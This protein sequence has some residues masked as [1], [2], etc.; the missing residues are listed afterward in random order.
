MNSVTLVGN[1]TRDPEI[2]DAGENKVAVLGIAETREGKDGEKTPQFYDVEVWGDL[3]IY[4]VASLAK[5]DLVIAVGH[6]RYDSYEKDGEKRSKVK[7]VAS[8]LGPSLRFAGATVVREE[9]VAT[10]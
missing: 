6:L 10:A 9:K 3:A 8:H 2:R 4:A 5:G 7:V 1:L